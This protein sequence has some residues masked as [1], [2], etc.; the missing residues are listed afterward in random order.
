M[1][2]Q[3]GHQSAIT[4]TRA[5]IR[6]PRAR[7][8]AVADLN[9]VP[10]RLHPLRRWRVSCAK[11]GC[12]NRHEEAGLGAGR[13]VGDVCRGEGSLMKFDEGMVRRTE[14]VMVVAVIILVLVAYV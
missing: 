4:C 8:G 5:R 11:R 10:A 2:H 9:I 6:G 13:P 14:L 3:R 7:H 1:R 12:S